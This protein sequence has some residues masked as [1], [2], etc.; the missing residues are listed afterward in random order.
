MGIDISHHNG[1]V[2]WDEV[3]SSS[4]EADAEIRF[5][6]IKVT[7]STYFID[8]C[9][10]FNWAAMGAAGVGRG[11]YHFFRPNRSG[12]DQAALF[13]REM[14]ELGVSRGDVAVIDIE[15]TDEYRRVEHE[16]VVS[17]VRAF[18]KAVEDAGLFSEK[19]VIYTSR[20]FWDSSDGMH[21][22]KAF[23]DYPLW[24]ANYTTTPPPKRPA[25]WSDW[26]AWQFTPNGTI[27]GV[28]G[29]VDLNVQQEPL[30]TGR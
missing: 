2:R 4:R 26:G 5:G 7:E 24:V 1:R 30:F 29:A 11:A 16:V 13:L 20:G 10:D 8:P 18:L 14:E 23:A 19:P 17:R 22:T 9:A 3:V 21:G 25:A 15:M 27:G 12:A 28:D 6:I